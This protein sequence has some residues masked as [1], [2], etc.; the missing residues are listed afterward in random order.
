MKYC[1][2]NLRREEGEGRNGYKFLAKAYF[3]LP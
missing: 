2:F 1:K 3:L